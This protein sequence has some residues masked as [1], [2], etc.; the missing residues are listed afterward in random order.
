MATANRSFRFAARRRLLQWILLFFTTTTVVAQPAPRPPIDE[1]VA[2]LQ[3]N[4]A[5]VR[6]FSA[7][8]EH[9]YR[10]G[11]IGTSLVEYGTVAIKKPGKMRWQYTSSE[12][13]LYVSD[14]E[15]FYS[16]FPLDR[17]V[18]IARLP[19]DDRASTPALFLAGRGDLTSDFVAAYEDEAEDITGAWTIRLTPTIRDTDYDWL[20]LRVDRIS[21][22][23]VGLTTIDSQGG[24]STYRFT[25]LQENRGLGDEMFSFQIPDGVDIIDDTASLQ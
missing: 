9:R 10:G 12:R 8:F 4:Y 1:L 7:D 11:L 20:V 23:I 13:K 24:E 15:T 18:V 22:S 3:Q 21:L 19:S 2:R 25:N 5:A 6:D 14:G 16:Y 17:Q